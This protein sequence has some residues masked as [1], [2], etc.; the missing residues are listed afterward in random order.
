MMT[1]RPD[2][3]TVSQHLAGSAHSWHG[4]ITSDGPFQPDEDRYHLYI[5]LFC[6]FAHRANIVRYLKGLHHLLPLSIVRAYPKGDEIGWPG[7]KFPAS[8]LKRSYEQAV[9]ESDP[10]TGKEV[11]GR[12]GPRIRELGNAITAMEESA[13]ED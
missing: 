9:K 13:L 11:Q 12:V 5:G 4:K 8:E 1:T 10:D 3:T 7:W 6:P 2:P